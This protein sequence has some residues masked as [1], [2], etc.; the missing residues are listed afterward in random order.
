V[1]YQSAQVF[2]AGRSGTLDKVSLM[3]DRATNNN[4]SAG[5]LVVNIHSVDVDGKPLDDVLGGGTYSGAGSP[6]TWTQISLPNTVP[7]TTG[8][9]Y[10]IV[11]STDATANCAWW[12]VYGNLYTGYLGGDHWNRTFANW[13]WTECC[14]GDEDDLDFITWVH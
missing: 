1:E 6:S 8:E 14:L 11:L 7:V 4:T 2:T 13:S 12:D 3:V 10:A 5:D 9:E